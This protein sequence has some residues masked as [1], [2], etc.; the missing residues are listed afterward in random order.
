MVQATNPGCKQKWN[1]TPNK[2][3]KH[4]LVAVPNIHTQT[5]PHTQPATHTPHARSPRSTGTAHSPISPPD[6][7][8]HRHSHRAQT[9]AQHVHTMD[10]PD[11]KA[12]ALSKPE[13]V[14]AAQTHSCTLKLLLK[15]S[16]PVDTFEFCTVLQTIQY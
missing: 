11:R 9:C 12:H 16:V 1:L 14:D 8:S 5:R 4:L 6:T 3:K 7:C 15:N 2:T 13:Q 10:T